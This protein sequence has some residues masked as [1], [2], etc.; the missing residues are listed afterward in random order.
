MRYKVA[1]VIYFHE[2]PTEENSSHLCCNC[3]FRIIPGNSDRRR[4]RWF[5]VVAIS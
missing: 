3:L 5:L 4:F 1:I 2:K